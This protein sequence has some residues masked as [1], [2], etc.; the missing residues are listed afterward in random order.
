MERDMETV[1]V[2][3]MLFVVSILFTCWVLLNLF[4]LPNRAF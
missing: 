4:L 3:M 1:M 2:R